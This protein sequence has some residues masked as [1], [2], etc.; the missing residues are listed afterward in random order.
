MSEISLAN[1]LG[2]N[3]FINSMFDLWQ[4]SE[5]I[6]G[7]LSSQYIAD[8]FLFDTANPIDAKVEKVSDVPLN[9]VAPNALKYLIIHWP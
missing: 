9:S 6:T 8:R 5:L 1:K 3:I 4:R 2:E 7:I